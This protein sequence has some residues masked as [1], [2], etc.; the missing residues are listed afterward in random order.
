MLPCHIFQ[1]NVLEFRKLVV[2]KKYIR[3]FQIVYFFVKCFRKIPERFSY[4]NAHF[5]SYI[6]VH[7]KYTRYQ[8]SCLLARWG[9]YECV[10]LSSSIGKL[11]FCGHFYFLS[12]L[13]IHPSHIIFRV[14]RYGTKII[15]A[16]RYLSCGWLVEDKCVR[17]KYILS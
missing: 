9:L 11:N 2:F 5:C 6:Q 15:A 14:Y 10:V 13:I 8:P 4:M 16:V 17:K 7:A 3:Y 12:L 1:K